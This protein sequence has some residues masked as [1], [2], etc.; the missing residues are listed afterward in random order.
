MP[1]ICRLKQNLQ[2]LDAIGRRNNGN[3]AF[4]TKGY[5]ESSN[6]VLSRISTK[7][8]SIFRTWTQYFNHTYEETRE[9]SVTGPD[10]EDVEVISLM[11]NNAT[12]LPNGVSGKLVAVPVDDARGR[13]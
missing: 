2:E 11:Y 5:L 1:T 4:G 12:P 9:I 3:R 10:G 13:F 8:D 7:E 6:Y